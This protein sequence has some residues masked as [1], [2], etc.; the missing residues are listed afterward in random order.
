[1]MK[2]QGPNKDRYGVYRQVPA[3]SPV[4][5]R[6]LCCDVRTGRTLLNRPT[7][8]LHEDDFNDNLWWNLHGYAEPIR[9]LE[10]KHPPPRTPET[11][12]CDTETAQFWVA[13]FSSQRRFHFKITNPGTLPSR[14]ATLLF[15]RRA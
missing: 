7:A 9:K 1:M 2:G 6:Y 3:M 13:F 11:G 14:G 4:R 5:K 15:A 12:L 8:T 10:W